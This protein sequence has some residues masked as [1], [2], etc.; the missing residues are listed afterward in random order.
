M[1]TVGVGVFV[2][3]EGKI[4]IGRRGPGCRRGI[5]CAALPGGHL[6][7]DE[8]IHECVMRECMEES[9]VLVHIPQH[10]ESVTGWM[11]VPG[12]L[13]VTDHL[14]RYH[15]ISQRTEHISLWMLGQWF[16][17]EPTIKEPEKC[18]GWEWLTLEEIAKIPGVWDRF[19][20]QFYWI[21]MPL[22]CEIL[23]PVFGEERCNTIRAAHEKE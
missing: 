18:T 5:N 13:A 7:S 19:E 23:K 12:L 9:G 6:E 14:C 15:T 10:P 16:G 21:P 20:E 8:T 11:R 17:G 2:V 4:L 1:R 22:W 3:K